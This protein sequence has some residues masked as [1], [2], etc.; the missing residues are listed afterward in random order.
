MFNKAKQELETG[1]TEKMSPTSYLKF[2]KTQLRY[3]MQV[4]Y[5]QFYFIGYIHLLGSRASVSFN[6]YVVKIRWVGGCVVHFCR[7]SGIEMST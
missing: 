2:P 1:E 4:L 7:R 6:V 3:N 5:V